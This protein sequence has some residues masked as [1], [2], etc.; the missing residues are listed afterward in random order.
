MNLLVE[1]LRLSARVHV[2]SESWMEWF[3]DVLSSLF[4]WPAIV[5][6]LLIYLLLSNHATRRVGELLKPFRSIKL[7]G[8]E[9]VLSEEGAREVATNVEASFA[10]YRQKVKREFDRQAQVYNL[11][12]KLEGV[13]KSDNVKS[14][15]DNAPGYRCT[16]HVPDIL[17]DETM[18]QLLD[19]YPAGGG[20]GRTWSARR[21]I[22]G[23]AWRLDESETQGSVPTD[24]RDLVLGW[25][26]TTDEAAA[27]GQGRKS[28]SCVVLR[29]A[30]QTAV[31]IFYLDAKKEDAFGV[32][33]QELHSAITKACQE[34]G[35]TSALAN[36]YQELSRR[37]PI[38][39]VH[40]Q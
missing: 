30:D 39:D 35:L 28:F 13:L 40:E 2:Q 14:V 20:R 8:A 19:Y 23:R 32:D 10:A 34:K 16:L 27:A 12:K 4:P 29:D 5:L 3:R 31:G 17:F 37:G 36:L 38:I 15:L 26:M 33:H 1:T 24:S 21:G 6:L 9:F 22:I 7:F 25:G 11:R 18:Y